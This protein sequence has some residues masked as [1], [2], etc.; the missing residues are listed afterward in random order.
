M[1]FSITI[2]KALKPD[3]EK[4][5]QELLYLSQQAVHKATYFEERMW[6]IAGALFL[7][8]ITNEV[9]YRYKIQPDDFEK[10]KD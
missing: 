6:D 10:L 2:N 4:V 1:A 7:T 3:I 5:E 9:L 8:D